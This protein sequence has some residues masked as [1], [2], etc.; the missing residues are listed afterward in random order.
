MK[1]G[2]GASQNRA[3]LAGRDVVCGLN[4]NNWAESSMEVVWAALCEHL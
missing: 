4:A 3:S 2:L 1:A